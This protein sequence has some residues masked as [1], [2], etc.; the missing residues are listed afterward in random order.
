MHN[1]GIISRR[2]AGFLPGKSFLGEKN[3]NEELILRICNLRTGYFHTRTGNCGGAQFQSA[4]GRGLA[5]RLEGREA[6]GKGGQNTVLHRS[7]IEHV[8]LKHQIR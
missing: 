8:R 3:E 7:A 5:P 6:C 1:F 4:K 2:V